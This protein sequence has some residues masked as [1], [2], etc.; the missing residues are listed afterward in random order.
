MNPGKLA[1]IVGLDPALPFFKMNEPDTR[2]AKTDAD[3]VET[4]HT[5]AGLLGFSE[6]LGDA[7]YFPNGGRSQPGCGWDPV[8]YCAHRR[9]YEF[10]LESIFHVDP[11]MAFE[12]SDLEAIR[13]GKCAVKNESRMVQM[14]GEPGVHKYAYYFFF[15]SIIWF[16]ISTSVFYFV[17]LKEFSILKLL[18]SQPSVLDK[19]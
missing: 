18:I 14:A 10:Y 15:F 16:Q 7:S 13:Q 1:K 11:Y 2:L 8:G 17:G 5:N 3:Y 9:S 12:C 19:M 6:P 4:I